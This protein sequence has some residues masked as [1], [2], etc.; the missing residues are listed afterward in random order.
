M[1]Y[2]GSELGRP[3]DLTGQ[4]LQPGRI[5]WFP[6]PLISGRLSST[7]LPTESEAPSLKKVQKRVTRILLCLTKCLVSIIGG[8]IGKNTD[9]RRATPL[10]R[11]FLNPQPHLTPQRWCTPK[12][13][14]WVSIDPFIAKVSS[15]PICAFV[16]SII[17]TLT[18]DSHR[19]AA[20]QPPVFIVRPPSDS[21]AID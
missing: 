6:T 11:P 15:V 10:Y 14:F 7:W 4:H 18:H 1:R 21:I 13:H 9:G 8:K 16:G 19:F 17:A 20:A 3:V 2:H 5:P 12:D